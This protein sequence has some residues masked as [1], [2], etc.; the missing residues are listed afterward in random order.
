MATF[1]LTWNPEVSEENF[2]SEAA[3]EITS[4]GLTVGSSWNA[5]GRKSGISPGDRV[6]LLQQGVTRGIVASGYARS[7]IYQG[8]HFLDEN[9][10][11]NYVDVEWDLIVSNDER[12]LTE[13]LERFLPDV[14]WT[15]MSSG[16]KVEAEHAAALEFLWE[17]GAET[18]DEYRLIKW[19]EEKPSV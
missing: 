5:G 9:K 14:H 12:L 1:L 3:I 8:T 15:P 7:E 17:Y 6:F 11:A 13:D 4:Q 19:P 10:E 2:N 18:V 16:N